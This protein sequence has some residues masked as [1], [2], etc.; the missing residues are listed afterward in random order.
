M[1]KVLKKIKARIERGWTRGAYA[2]D[3]QGFSC[4]GGAQEAVCWCLEGAIRA[5]GSE[6]LVRIL[7]RPYVDDI[8][9][10]NDSHSKEEVLA[11]LDAAIADQASGKKVHLSK[12]GK[13]KCGRTNVTTTTDDFYVT[14]KA[15]D[16]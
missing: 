6:N 9:P 16:K 8:V 4:H 5:E 15:C 7:L 2:R 12:A 1:I 11:V 10:F 14:C 13:A 3:A